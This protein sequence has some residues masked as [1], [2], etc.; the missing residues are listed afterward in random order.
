MMRMMPR[1]VLLLFALPAPAAA[2]GSALTLLKSVTPSGTAW[3]GTELSYSVVVTNDSNGPAHAVTL[4]DQVPAECDFKLDSIVAQ[5]GATGL[6]P[7]IAYSSDN[8]STWTYLPMSGAGGAPAGFDG[9]V[10]TIRWSLVGVL[11][12]T[13]PL[14]QAM[15]G[16]M[17]RIR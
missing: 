10:T 7:V 13:A 6:V 1:A 16:F 14:N 9:R 3:P 5:M 11:G 15:V 4:Q 2:A 8:G 12:N 17:V